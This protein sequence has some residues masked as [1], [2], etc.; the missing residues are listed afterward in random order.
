MAKSVICHHLTAESQDLSHAVP[1]GF[2]DRQSAIGIDIIWLLR[3]YPS[4]IVT[5]ILLMHLYI[6]YQFYVILATT[7]FYIH[8]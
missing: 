6:D 8:Y 7:V 5:L 1:C 2:Y 3:Y 4:N